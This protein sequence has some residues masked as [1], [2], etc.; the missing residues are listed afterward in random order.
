VQV[1]AGASHTLGLKS[2]GTVLAVGDNWWGQLDVAS[3]T[4]IVQVA[5]GWGHT[6]GLKSDGTVLAVGNNND[7]ELNVASWTDIVQVA[8]GASHTVGLKSDSSVVAVG[9][10][11][12][13]E[14]NVAS[15]TYIVQVASGGNHTVGMNSDGTVVAV[16]DNGY[17]QLDVASWTDIVQ[18]AAGWGHTVGLKSDGTV[19]AVGI[20]WY[21]Q[22]NVSDW[23]L[24]PYFVDVPI[25]YWAEDHIN[26]IY[27]V[28]FTKGCSK[29]PPKY[30]PTKDVTREQTSAFIVRA[31]EGEPPTDYCDTGSPFSDVSPS[32]TFCKYIKRLLELGITKGCGPGIY[33]PNNNV[34]RAEMAAF[35]IRAVEG[36]PPAD[37]C[38]TGS[39]FSDVPANTWPCK[40]IKRLLELGIT[41]GC[42]A[43]KYCPNR[44]VTR[45]EMAAF[46]GRAFL[47]MD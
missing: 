29:N 20:N 6:V 11:D 34:T 3:W 30:C 32:A 27:N 22:C 36:E 15:W 45:A 35:L 4:D 44:N 2:D 43:G 46:L 31:V 18:V 47:E 16:G 9:N 33:C 38:D 7:G 1:A 23:D 8:A 17:G 5:A 39:P 41:K 28:G 25:G 10:N 19:L 40:Y 21:G 42:G 26:A 24:Q 37:Y 14:L 12:D 13:G